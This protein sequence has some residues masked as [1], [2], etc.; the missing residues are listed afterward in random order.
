MM[1]YPGL[2]EKIRVNFFFDPKKRNSRSNSQ[3]VCAHLGTLTYNGFNI[4][5]DGK[6]Q[7]IRCSKCSKRFGKD[8]EMRNLLL[9]QQ[10]IK[11]ILY[12]LFILKYPLTGVAIQWGIPQDKLS[13]FKKSVVSHV[14]QQNSEVIEQKLKA[15]PRGVILGDETY[16]GTR[17]NSDTEIIFINDNYET[18]SIGIA[19]EGDLKKSILGA[20]HKIPEV[21]R[22]KLK[23]L[24]T[25]GEPSYKAIAKI[26]GSKVI[27]VAQ[28]HTQ[29]Q[30]GKV[31]IS[32]YKKLGPHFLHY[33]ISTHWKAF[34]RNKHEL[35]FKW[36]I[37]FIKGK[38]QAK[39]GRPRK[40]DRSQNKNERWRQKLEK[41]HFDVFQKE[42]TAKIFVNFETNKLSM[43]AGAKKWMIQLLTPIFKIFK[44]KYITTN[45]MESKH[46]QVKRNGVRKK[47]R[48][49]EYGYNLY[50]LHTFLVEYGYIPFTNL[51]GRPL[52]RYLIKNNKKERMGY[53][54]PE[55]KRISIQ[56]V[57]STYE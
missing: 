45:L 56:T 10:K 38:V 43:H 54:I 39:R 52:Y 23:V 19:D 30:R 47:Q 7:R 11:K 33:K 15:L 28:L 31:I 27:H 37:K 46:S 12:E 40:S 16:I 14:F 13:K 20:F 3:N 26:F 17:G 48:D 5:K 8:I 42:G 18:L 53:R 4:L 36:E 32:K 25:D 57:L 34:Y 29:K 22:E 21:C 2:D 1:N 24:I 49:R 44:G 35:K 9:Y 55:G 41:Y 50:M 6:I 51:T